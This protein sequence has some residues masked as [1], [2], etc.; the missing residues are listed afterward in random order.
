M[1]KNIPLIFLFA[2]FTGIAALTL[3]A[4]KTPQTSP[5]LAHSAYL[6]GDSI[7]AVN[8]L[9]SLET[10]DR[11]DTTG[12]HPVWGYRYQIPGD[13]NGDGKQETLTEY[14]TDRYGHEIPKYYGEGDI[15]INRCFEADCGMKNFLW[16][17]KLK[18]DTLFCYHLHFAEN[19]G[20]LN[21]DGTDELGMISSNG[22]FSSLSHYSIYTLKKGQ[23][24]ELLYIP[25]WEWM[26]PASPLTPSSYYLFGHYKDT[27]ITN[28]SININLDAER[29][30]FDFVKNLGNGVIEFEMMNDTITENFYAGAD[31]IWIRYNLKN[32]TFKVKLPDYFCDQKTLDREK[33]TYKKLSANEF[34]IGS[35]I[36][37]LK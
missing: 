35:H 25:A 27:L 30:K 1:L 32:N 33:I 24:K 29:K 36:Y 3:P 7:D 34:K 19:L 2:A 12:D 22:D 26:F 15:D 20:D 14:F 13:F 6:I 16:N 10:I 23:W 4:V 21:G 37:Y 9:D 8:T 17:R 31:G 18:N 28:D 5:Y 11:C